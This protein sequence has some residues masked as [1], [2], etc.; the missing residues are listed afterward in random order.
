MN[1]CASEPSSNFQIRKVSS[2]G[3]SCMSNAALCRRLRSYR[4]SGQRLAETRSVSIGAPRIGGDFGLFI[5]KW[6]TPTHGASSDGFE[7]RVLSIAIPA[8]G[9]G[10]PVKYGAGEGIRT[11]DPDL[12]KVV[13]YP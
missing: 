7:T 1:L 13:L 4:S 11:L 2:V 10:V 8:T 6:G 5:E 3:S 9:W 12:G